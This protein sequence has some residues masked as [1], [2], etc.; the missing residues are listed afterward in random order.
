M[1][2]IGLTA[3]TKKSKLEMHAHLQ[4]EKFRTFYKYIDL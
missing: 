3:L 4:Y 2:K 1:S